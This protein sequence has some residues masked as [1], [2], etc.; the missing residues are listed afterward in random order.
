[1]KYGK[2]SDD[3]D[4]KNIHTYRWL[5]TTGQWNN[6]FLQEDVDDF[7]TLPLTDAFGFES[8]FKSKDNITPQI[9]T[10]YPSLSLDNDPGDG[11]EYSSMGIKTIAVNYNKDSKNFKTNEANVEL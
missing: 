5:Y 7:N 4:D 1:M 2:N 11:G 9:F 6:K 10:N 8:K 3:K